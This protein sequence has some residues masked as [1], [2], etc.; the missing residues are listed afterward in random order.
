MCQKCSCVNRE[1]FVLLVILKRRND[2]AL[3][4]REKLR[5]MKLYLVRFVA[6]FHQ[7]Q[8]VLLKLYFYI[9]TVLKYLLEIFQMKYFF[10]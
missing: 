1:S 7:K 2:F 8:N 6:S 5:E 3:S 4:I 10:K 9:F